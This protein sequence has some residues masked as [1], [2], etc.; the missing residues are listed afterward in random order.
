MVKPADSYDQSFVATTANEMVKVIAEAEVMI[1]AGNVG[2]EL[3][4]LI[5]HARDL[6]DILLDQLIEAE[7]D[8]IE[9]VR[10]LCDSLG[11]HIANLEKA[12]KVPPGGVR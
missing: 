11:N 1:E 10:G 5:G 8:S 6:H 9:W 4:E 7:P 2:Q 12:A 3:R